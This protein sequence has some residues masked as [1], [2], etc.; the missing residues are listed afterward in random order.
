M[1]QNAQLCDGDGHN[2][3]RSAQRR[4]KGLETQKRLEPL[5]FF[6]LFFCCYTNVCLRL[7][8]LVRLATGT[9]TVAPNRHIDND[10]GRGLR[11]L[12]E[13][14]FMRRNFRSTGTL[15]SLHYCLRIP[16]NSNNSTTKHCMNQ[17]DPMFN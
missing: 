3:H 15:R 10:N 16:L 2:H 6:P 1:T 7:I 5:V 4:Q 9:T 13:V 17:H 8:R 12:R 14:F 11:S